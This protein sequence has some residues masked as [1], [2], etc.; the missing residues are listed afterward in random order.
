MRGA[1]AR[2]PTA[3]KMLLILSLALLPIGIAMIWTAQSGIDHAN[4]L[5]DQRAEEQDQA[6]SRA[7][8][9]LIARNALALRIAVNAAIAIP[10]DGDC[11]QA[12]RSL[13]IAPGVSRSF[14]IERADGSEHCVTADF[15]PPASARF[16]APGGIALWL[17]PAGGA[18]FIRVGLDGG[19]ATDRL[20]FSELA[21]AARD[22]APGII[23]LELDDGV[24]AAPV[25]GNR[26]VVPHGN[27]ASTH[28]VAGGQL[29]IRVS[30]PTERLSTGEWLRRRGLGR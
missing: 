10:G 24:N 6:A 25:I 14:S 7:I 12:G 15:R 2:L 4:S 28:R 22:V 3:A 23:S 1:F 17:D 18:L 20:P 21:A 11:Q 19:M 29:A 16:A 5:L 8:E 13:S 27:R 30:V 9:S 26:P